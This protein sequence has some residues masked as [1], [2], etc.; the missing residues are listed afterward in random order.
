MS[1]GIFCFSDF[2][3]PDFDRVCVRIHFLS[4]IFTKSKS[5]DDLRYTER[6]KNLTWNVIVR[7][8]DHVICNEK[9]S[10]FANH[11]YNEDMQKQKNLLQCKYANACV[12]IIQPLCF[13]RTDHWTGCVICYIL[14]AEKK[15]KERCFG[16]FYSFGYLYKKKWKSIERFLIPCT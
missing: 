16:V 15:L 4:I 1:R 3:T 11:P 9:I 12:N 5:R 10:A 8:K 2:V 6:Q 13:M 7:G 14:I